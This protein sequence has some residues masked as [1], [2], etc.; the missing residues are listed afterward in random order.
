MKSTSRI[1]ILI[2]AASLW[3][4]SPTRHVPQGSYL[5]DKVDIEV[6][7]Q[8]G[9]TTVIERSELFNYLRQ[10]P[11]HKVLGFAK[12]QLGIYNM[13]GSDSTRWYNR[14]LRR[15]GQAPVI[16]SPDQTDASAGQLRQAMVNKGYLSAQVE[17]DS[18]V[19]ADGNRIELRYRVDPGRAHR[20]NSLQYEIS[21]TAIAGI[22]ADDG[23]SVLHI[24]DNLD[25]SALDAERTRITSLL[26]DKG[27]YA[28]SKEYVTFIADTAEHSLDVDL[29]MVVH[30]E[31]TSS[32]GPKVTYSPDHTYIINRVI[33]VTGLPL[34]ANPADGIPPGADTVRY[35]DITVVYANG[36]PYLRPS[37]LREKCFLE[38]DQPY[39]S[40]MVDR[41]Y[42]ALAQLGIVRSI[43]I[44]FVP[45]GVVDGH[46]MLDAYIV[47]GRNKK[48]GITAEL[49]G[50]NSEGDFGFGVG[51]AYQHRNLARRSNLLTTKLRI[52]Y[53]SLSGNFTDLINDRYTEYAAEASITFPKFMMPLTRRAFRRRSKASTELALSFNYQERPE[54]TRVI[55]G[56]AWKY[57]W[58]NRDNTIR[59]T[60]DLVDVNYVYLPESTI[61]FINQIAPDN[62][63]LRY[64]YEDHFI[65]RM[66]YTYYRTNRRIATANIGRYRLQPSVYTLRV[67][68]ET[69]GNLLYA[70]SSLSDQKRHGGVYKLF[71][72][73]YS[74]YAKAEIDYAHTINLT[75]RQALAFHTGFGIGVPY[76]NSRVLPFEK[77]F[78]AGGANG[79]RGWGVRTLGPGSFDSKNSVTDFINQCGDIS[80][81]LS[82]EYR[83]KLFWVIEGALFVDAGNIW[84]I[85]NYENQ[86]G[87][88]FK[89][90][91]FWRQIAMAYGLGIRLDFSYFLLRFDLG[92]KAYNPADGQERWPLI[93]PRWK[94]DT[95][96]HFA[97][98]YPF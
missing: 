31:P 97:V 26:R 65:M 51:L 42:E 60:W 33:F 98:G 56:A 45:C 93:H 68:A 52:N 48:Q 24:G 17:V 19:N 59:R 23:L 15:L 79:V 85:H 36:D 29:T 46:D 62:P 41:T 90:N 12:M 21:D 40:T 6:D 22:L 28:F 9:D 91:K 64:S 66:G 10:Q 58:A 83:A 70:I 4:C 5:L 73:Q 75:Q 86:P 8:P 87:G 74:Q 32:S 30:P 89:F 39:S 78:Y 57:R 11:N 37:I 80:L 1:A 44:D 61:D 67:A 77:R 54:Y 7:M 88:M 63:L 72:I 82:A 35:K 47:L 18:T 95:A 25:R 71:G 69:A 16:Y 3:A 81:N 50:T 38:P 2:A 43:S 14:W 94:R 76:G 53:E 92:V 55:A 96:F 20:I 13:S 34:G 84:T 27:Y 49:E